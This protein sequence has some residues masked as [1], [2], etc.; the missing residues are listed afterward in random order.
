MPEP[1]AR[2]VG[3]HLKEGAN[4]GAGDI[5]MVFI[6]WRVYNGSGSKRTLALMPKII[7]DAPGPASYIPVAQAIFKTFRVVKHRWA[8]NDFDIVDVPAGADISLAGNGVCGF[9]MET[10]LYVLASV[11]AQVNRWIS[12][13]VAAGVVIGWRGVYPFCCALGQDLYPAQVA[14]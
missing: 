12:P 9:E 4:Q 10:D 3:G 14:A 11:I 8:G 6:G 13:H 7:V 2:V 1:Q 5:V